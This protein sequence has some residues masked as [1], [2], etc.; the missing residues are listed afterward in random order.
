M[1]RDFPTYLFLRSEF[2]FLDYG[3]SLWAFYLDYISLMGLWVFLAHYLSK[4]LRKL[5]GVRNDKK[6]NENL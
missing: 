6:G 1:S 4:R 5:A 3:E 2:V